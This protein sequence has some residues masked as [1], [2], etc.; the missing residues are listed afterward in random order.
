MR[1]SPDPTA[2][3][4]K[5]R[6]IFVSRGGEVRSIKFGQ[7][8]YC[9]VVNVG[10]KPRLVVE[11]VIWGLVISAEHVWTVWP[12]QGVVWLIQNLKI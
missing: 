7:C 12:L 6:N 3:D 2:A 10:D 9:P 11:V 5:K 8:L 1:L 4:V